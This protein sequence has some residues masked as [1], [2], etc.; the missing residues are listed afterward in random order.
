M[1]VLP[2]GAACNRIN[3]IKKISYDFVDESALGFTIALN[4]RSVIDGFV[5]ANTVMVLF[6]SPILPRLLNRTR[7]DDLAPGATGSRG[8]S[9]VV[10]PQEAVM[11]LI[12]KGNSPL[13]VKANVCSTVS[14]SV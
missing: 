12:I 14:P 5:L 10:Q 2:V 1:G 11:L 4:C 6:C 7:I 9:G 13:L 8:H 3:A